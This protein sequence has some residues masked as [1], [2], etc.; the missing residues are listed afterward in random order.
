M[1]NT[2]LLNFQNNSIKSE[3]QSY[4]S[5]NILRKTF[6]PVATS[7]NRLVYEMSYDT[8]KKKIYQIKYKNKI[9]CFIEP[10]LVAPKIINKGPYKYEFNDSNFDIYV[11]ATS[12][13]SLEKQIKEIFLMLWEEY[14]LEDDSNLTNKA[15]ELKKLLLKTLREQ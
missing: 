10:Y 2:T 12:H 1:N 13:V 5:F 3:K 8:L 9:L 11:I 6:G 7:L 4:N 15:I 14:A